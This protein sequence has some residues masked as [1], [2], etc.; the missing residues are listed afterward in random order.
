M[1]L[2]FLVF[3]VLLASCKASNDQNNKAAA[4]PTASPTDGGM[5]IT[6]LPDGTTIRESSDGSTVTVTTPNGAVTGTTTSV[7]A[8]SSS[9]T[10]GDVTIF[11]SDGASSLAGKERAVLPSVADASSPTNMW[12]A[13]TTVVVRR[14]LTEVS[15]WEAMKTACGSSGT[16]ILSDGFVMGTYASTP[17]PQYGGIDF[18]GKQLVIIGNSKTLDAGEKG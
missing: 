17:A 6:A 2:S 11:T 4:A 1:K 15:N 16:V 13:N 8:G 3:A 7:S 18:S 10:V 9:T 5:T 12:V 14:R